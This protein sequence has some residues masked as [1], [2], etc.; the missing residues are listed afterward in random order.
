MSLMNSDLH[1]SNH[2]AVIA[3][4]FHMNTGHPRL[5]PCTAPHS[6]RWPESSFSL[7]E[8][9]QWS[10]QLNMVKSKRFINHTVSQPSTLS[11]E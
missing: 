7:V 5:C 2:P 6:P 1:S 3:I 11:K 9:G 10:L 8:T 4:R